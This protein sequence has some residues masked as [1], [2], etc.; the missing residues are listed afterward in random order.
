MSN[1]RLK[2]KIRFYVI[3]AGICL[4]SA[5]GINI[6]ME[7]G[8][9]EPGQGEVLKSLKSELE[10]YRE[11][12][13]DKRQTEDLVKIWKSYEGKLGTEE[14]QK[15]KQEYRGKLSPADAEG[16]RK[17]YEDKSGKKP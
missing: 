2:K 1:D 6:L 17:V 7:P 4:I 9:P 13:G 3:L 15:L 16:L 5:A 12:H 14:M 8:S 10:W 11:L